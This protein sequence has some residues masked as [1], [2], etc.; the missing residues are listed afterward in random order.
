M[1]CP[2][3]YNLHVLDC[4]VWPFDNK[5]VFEIDFCLFESKPL[6]GGS[7]EQYSIVGLR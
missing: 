1:L 6:I 3:L 2:R 5:K 7:I 4:S